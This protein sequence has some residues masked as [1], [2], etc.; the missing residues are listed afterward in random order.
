[1]IRRHDRALAQQRLVQRV[2]I[3]RTAVDKERVAVL[4]FEDDGI[5]GVRADYAYRL[6]GIDGDRSPVMGLE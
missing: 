2:A 6:I 3:K 4:E 1:M 5:L